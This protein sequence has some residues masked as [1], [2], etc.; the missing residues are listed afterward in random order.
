MLKIVTLGKEHYDEE[1][2]KFVYPESTVI[3]L[4]HSLVSLSKWESKYQRPFLKKGEKSTE[5]VLDYIKMMILTPDLPPE[6]FV[7][8]IE[9]HVTEI[10]QYI[11]SKESATTFND[12]TRGE[13]NRETVTAELVYYWMISN[14]IPFECQYW[15]IN[16]LFTLIRVCGVKTAKPKKMSMSAMAAQRRELNAQRKAQSGTSG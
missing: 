3:E 4:E 15:H 9:K 8:L 2:Q 10:N 13:I 1:E 5:E 12:T 6:V 7:E 16:R 14:N 11:E